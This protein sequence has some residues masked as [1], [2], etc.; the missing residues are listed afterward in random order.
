MNLSGSFAPGDAFKLFNAVAYIGAFDNIIP[1]TPAPG[2]MWDTSALGVNGTL[3]V[4]VAP[5]PFITSMALSGTNTV[6][7]GTNGQR[8]GTYWVRA[9]TNITLPVSTWPVIATNI[10]DSTGAFGVTNAVD[11]TASQL[12]YLLQLQ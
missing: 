1:A 11:P 2:L 5:P 12:F 10:F 3:K 7:N 8:N 4:A 6:F 9:S